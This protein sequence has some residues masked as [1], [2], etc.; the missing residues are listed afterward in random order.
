[1]KIRV[2]EVR[3]ASLYYGESRLWEDEKEV[4]GRRGGSTKR[5]STKLMSQGKGLNALSLFRLFLFQ[6]L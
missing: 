1:M 6:S 2:F 3:K 4:G 5:Q